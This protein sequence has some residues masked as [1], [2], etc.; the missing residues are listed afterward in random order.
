MKDMVKLQ[1]IVIIQE[2]R[3][4]VHS[5]YKFKYIISKKIATAFH[6]GSN[7]DYHFIVKELAEKWKI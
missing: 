6:N 5:I 4:A 7:Y 1:V 2:N 3:G